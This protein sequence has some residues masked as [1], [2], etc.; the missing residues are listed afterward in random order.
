MN[1]NG[2]PPDPTMEELDIFL[3]NQRKIS[4]E[5]LLPYAGKQVAWSIDSARIIASG[6]DMDEVEEKVV[7]AGV[8]PN[9][10]VFGFID[11]PEVSYLG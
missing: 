8:A 6:D 3:E 11:D 5:E 4:P 2:Q 9:R 1:R 7:A 10:V